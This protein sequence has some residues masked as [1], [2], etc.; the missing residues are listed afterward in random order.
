MHHI[1]PEL[2]IDSI[3]SNKC[4]S[5][6]ITPHFPSDGEF[7]KF[8]YKAS[9]KLEEMLQTHREAIVDLRYSHQNNAA[10]DYEKKEWEPRFGQTYKVDGV[11]PD[12]DKR[13]VRKH[14]PIGSMFLDTAVLNLSRDDK[15]T[16]CQIDHFGGLAWSVMVM[17]DDIDL[18]HSVVSD[19]MGKYGVDDFDNFPIRYAPDK[20]KPWPRNK[21]ED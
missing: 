10:Y 5:S 6:S 20:D 16:Y 12:S 17:A 13:L 8:E 7:Y 18:L 11:F 14:L 21:H 2:L 15:K 4:V 3:F 1:D 9:L 19:I